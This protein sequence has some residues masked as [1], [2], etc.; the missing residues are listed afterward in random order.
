MIPQGTM[1]ESV[2]WRAY[3]PIDDSHTMM[4]TQIAGPNFEKRISGL[5]GGLHWRANTS[6]WLGRYHLTQ[7]QHNDFLIDREVQKSG[8]S[9]TGIPGGARPEDM[10]MTWSMGAI[11]DRSHEHLGT[12]DALI[13]RTRRRM[14]NAAKALRDQGTPPPASEDASIYAQRSGQVVLP[15]N[16]DWWEETREL[17]KAFV[18]HEGLVP[19]AGGG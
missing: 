18:R 6:G 14:I 1:G 2:F 10:A 17:R 3:V 7:D 8:V 9:Y 4:W 19:L 11:Y 15:R 13:I 12:T 16:A 5:T